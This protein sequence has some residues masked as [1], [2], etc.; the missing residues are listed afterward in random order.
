MKLDK[1]IQS[2]C[3]ISMILKDKKCLNK[4]MDNEGKLFLFRDQDFKNHGD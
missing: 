2:L 1:L 3:G 4:K